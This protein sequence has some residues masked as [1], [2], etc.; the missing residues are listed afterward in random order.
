MKLNY[1]LHYAI[2]I[3]GK[4][5][6]EQFGEDGYYGPDE[7]IDFRISMQIAHHG[8]WPPQFP[9]DAHECLTGYWNKYGTRYRQITKRQWV[10]EWRAWRKYINQRPEIHNVSNLYE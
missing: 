2:S 10:T 5:V 7:K 1:D 6:S 3:R 9:S 4:F 8:N